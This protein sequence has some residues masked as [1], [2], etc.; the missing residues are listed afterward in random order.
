[1]SENELLNKAVGK[2]RRQ[3]KKRKRRKGRIEREKMRKSCF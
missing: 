1:M 2:V 3:K